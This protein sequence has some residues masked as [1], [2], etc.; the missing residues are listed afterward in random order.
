M[1]PRV[2]VYLTD[3]MATALDRL[4][5]RPGVSKSALVEAA[6][7][8]F[9][10]PDGGDKREAALARRL[11]RLTRQFGRLERDLMILTEAFALFARTELSVL[12]SLSPA[13]QAAVRALGE[14]RFTAFATELARRLEKGKRLFRD[15]V[16]EVSPNA[17]DFF[18]HTEV[19]DATLK[20]PE[21]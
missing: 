17:A 21:A 15:A 9:L 10:S 2:H 13:D 16:E 1:K 11:D 3:D 19:D 20:E 12:P 14:E 7:R 4:A 8:T 5:T 18:S 6:L